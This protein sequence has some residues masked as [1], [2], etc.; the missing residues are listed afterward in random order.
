MDSHGLT[1]SVTAQHLGRNACWSKQLVGKSQFLKLVDN[2]F[3]REALARTS[4]T[5]EHRHIAVD[6]KLYCTKLLI[7]QRFVVCSIDLLIALILEPPLD[8]LSDVLFCPMRM[9][10]ANQ[11]TS[12]IIPNA[13]VITNDR[14]DILDG[15]RRKVVNLSCKL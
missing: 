14:Y 11:M 13:R 1:T 3:G 9:L 8:M 6:G 2:C 7:C 5:I 4:I 15:F 10:K 12:G